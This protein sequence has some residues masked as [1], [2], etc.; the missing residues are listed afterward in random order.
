[1]AS[2]SLTIDLEGKQ[3]IATLKAL[4]DGLDKLGTEGTKKVKALDNG[5]GSLVGTLGGIV[6]FKALD[7]LRTE[8]AD[9]FDSFVQF[10]KGL[11]DV[12]KTANLTQKETDELAVS[13]LNL[14]KTIPASTEEL[15]GIATAAGQLG[16]KGTKDLTLFT[17]TIA[18]LGRVSNLSG[19]QAA[20]TLTRILNV[21]GENIDTI[22]TFAS[23]IVS[24]GNNFAAT[25]S[26]IA[27]MANELARAT[28]QFGVSAS[29]S[30]AL[31]ATLRSLGVR[32]EEAGGVISNS[33]VKINEAIQSGGKGLDKLSELTG[34]SGEEIKKAFSED[35]IGFFR[36]FVAGLSNAEGGIANA[37]ANL[38][39]LGIEGVRVQKVLPVLSQNIGEFDRALGLANTEMKNATS[40]N[41]EYAKSLESTDSKTK[42]LNNSLERLKIRLGEKFSTFFSDLAPFIAESLDKIGKSKIEIFVEGTDDLNKLN[43]ELE[44]YKNKQK[45][46]DDGFF[47]GDPEEVAGAID[48]LTKRIATLR[49]TNASN[50]LASLKTELL[51]LD[52]QI[53]NADPL[54]PSIFGG[55]DELEERKRLVLEQIANVEKAAILSG[56][57]VAEVETAKTEDLKNNLAIRKSI[58]D[59]F[60]IADKEAKTSDRELEKLENE[61]AVAEDLQFLEDALGAEAAAKE[62][63]RI[64]EIEGESKRAI[65]LKKLRDKAIEENKI[66]LLSTVESQKKYG[67]QRVAAQKQVLSDIAGLQSSSNS[68]AF[69]VGKAAALALAYINTQQSVTNA[70]ANVPYPFN[71]AAAAA[72]GAAGAINIAN[73]ASAK[74][75]SAGSF[76]EGGI[77]GGN[78]FS[79]DNLTA[80]VNSGEAILTR[81]QQTNL[82]NAVDSGNIGSGGTNIT[83]NNPVLMS[84]DGVGALIDEINNA[85]EFKNKELKVS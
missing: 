20:T 45:T 39:V 35:A 74:P 14:T 80:N 29:E 5:F 82:F 62:L 64:K 41:E 47:T 46:I 8:L 63:N 61:I 70:L 28:A 84:E 25:E 3:A 53:K 7:F 11:I 55:K 10:E 78:S 16:V 30:A 40:L 68:T 4:Q 66:G 24:L 67:A 43:K 50:T 56:E 13:I 21:T 34:K 6:A 32:S 54:L 9:T 83:I 18:K 23:V 77:V 49:D 57:K 52:D 69:A 44:I 36:D 26:E 37:S 27:D 19:D 2:I 48:L 22:D 72:V 31:G 1:M 81:R 42:L 58:L 79:G 85:I 73:I 17:D 76:A 51:S 60:R 12:T 33:F 65:E 59:E 71:F 38:S 15:L 75:P